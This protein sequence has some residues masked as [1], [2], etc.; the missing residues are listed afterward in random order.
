MTDNPVAPTKVGRPYRSWDGRGEFDCIVIGSGIGALSTAALLAKRA[1][2]RVLVL[3]RHYV[4]GGYTHVFRRP[5]YEWDIGVHYVG[6][7]HQPDS[8]L[9]TI[10]N[11]ITDGQVDWVSTGDVY[12]RIVIA[13]EAYD[14]VAGRDRFRSSLV[15]YFPAEARRS[16]V[17]STSCNRALV[18][19]GFTLRKKPS[20]RLHCLARRWSNAL[21]VPAP[22]AG[23]RRPKC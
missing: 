6:Q 11:E 23:A 12:D 21:A 9:G 15:R 4:A 16:T 18:P 13:D 8:P 7:L 5:G 2:H 22:R 17:I 10:F 14:F 20:L 1:R 19:V 3:E